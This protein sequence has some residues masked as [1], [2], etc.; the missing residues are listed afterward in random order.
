[1]YTFL[2]TMQKTAL[3]IIRYITTEVEGK[4]VP[5]EIMISDVQMMKFKIR[6][7]F[8]DISMIEHLER[9]FIESLWRI[10]KIDEIVSSNIQDL[11][12]DEREVLFEYM[13]SLE[14]NVRDTMKRSFHVHGAQKDGVL[15]LEVFKELH[16]D[17]HIH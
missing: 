16:L 12:E 9:D 11:D 8:G 6:S 4:K 2:T 1:M 10:G 5:L 7:L 14:Q 15:K 17:S 3:D 13:D